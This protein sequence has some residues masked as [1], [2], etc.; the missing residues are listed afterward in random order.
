MD[1]QVVVDKYKAQGSTKYEAKDYD[2]KDYDAK[3]Y[4]PRSYGA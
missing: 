4:A 3:D 2:A 1:S